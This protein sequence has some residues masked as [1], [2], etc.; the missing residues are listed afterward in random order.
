MPVPTI[1]SHFE[2]DLENYGWPG[3]IRELHH[4]LSRAAILEDGPILRGTYFK[5]RQPDRDNDG[6]TT[7]RR[8]VGVEEVEDAIRRFSGNKSLAAEFLKTSRKTLYAKLR[9]GPTS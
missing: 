3:N 2:A 7:R 9:S 4:I 8:Q 6:G 1:D 5:Q